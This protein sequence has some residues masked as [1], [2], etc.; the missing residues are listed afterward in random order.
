[1]ATRTLTLEE[2]QQALSDSRTRGGYLA[3]VKEFFSS[4][5]L[6][7]DFTEKYPGK[8]SNS[9]RNSVKQNCDKIASEPNGNAP[10]HQIVMVPNGDKKHVVLINM[11]VY[12]LRKQQENEQ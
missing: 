7:F 4:G 8:D 1:M 10:K 12:Q 9:L 5:E 3:D 11:D 2:I 6:V